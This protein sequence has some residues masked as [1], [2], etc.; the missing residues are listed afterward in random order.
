MAQAIARF[1]ICERSC[2]LATTMLVGHVRDAHRRVGR[3]D[4]L[5]AGAGGAIGVD[6]AVAFL[7][8]DLDVVVDHRK[9]PDAG[10][11]G[12]PARVAVVGRDA[13]QPVHARFGLEPAVG[14]LALDLQRRRLDAGLLA[15][16]LL[17]QRH[18]VAA[19]PRPSGCTC[20]SASRPSPGSRCR[21][22]RRAP[23][24]RCR[25]RRPRRTAAPRTSLAARLLGQALERSL[26]LVDGR[27]VLLGFAELDQ[28][29]GVVELPLQ[30]ADAGRALPAAAA[31][32]A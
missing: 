11:A 19:R 32:R 9:D 16:A 12:V 2:W 27:L 25:C 22:R 6:A 26:A 8:V 30:L 31:A 7:D 17:D 20:A 10:K 4:V 1:L 18:L 29:D 21:R 23:R 28:D 14:V 13:H 24:D 15:R 5:A 3:V